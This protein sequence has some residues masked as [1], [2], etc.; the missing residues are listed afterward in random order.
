MDFTRFFLSI[1][2][3]VVY[4]ISLNKKH[5]FAQNSHKKPKS[6]G[7]P[8]IWVYPPLFIFYFNYASIVGSSSTFA[9]FPART[10]QMTIQAIDM[11]ASS[12]ASA[13]DTG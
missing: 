1:Q 12:A 9:F 10:C 8:H 7:Y 2:D 4:G 3:V 13:M 5:Y 6:G 11:T